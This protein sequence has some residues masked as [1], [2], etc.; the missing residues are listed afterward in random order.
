MRPLHTRLVSLLAT[1]MSFASRELGAAPEGVPGTRNKTT[2][3]SAVTRAAASLGF[4]LK[5]EQEECIFQLAGG[6]DVFVSLPT[7]YG[8]SLCYTI[9]P[10][11]FDQLRSIQKQSII[12]VVSPL[13]ALMKDQVAA[14]KIA[15][16]LLH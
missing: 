1:A 11:V 15:S 14:G 3:K 9:L 5:K 7:G 6:K 13:R 10:S 8:K 16:F 2:I 12:L 4:T